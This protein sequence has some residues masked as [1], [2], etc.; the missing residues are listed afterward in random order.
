[1]LSRETTS[2][3]VPSGMPLPSAETLRHMSP[4]MAT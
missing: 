1:M 3:A 4:S 2:T